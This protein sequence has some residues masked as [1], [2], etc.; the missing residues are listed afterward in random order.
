M[1][2]PIAAHVIGSCA[3]L[4]TPLH[5]DTLT[6][7]LQG[8]AT[9]AIVAEVTDQLELRLEDE[10]HIRIAGLEQLTR[11][12]PDGTLAARAELTALLKGRTIALRPLAPK[13]D[14]WGRSPAQVFGPVVP[15]VADGLPPV[16]LPYLNEALV[17]AG[18]FRVQPLS[19][20]NDCL[21]ILLRAEGEARE[22]GFGLWA[23]PAN[24]PI[25]AT[26]TDAL[27]ARNGQFTLVQGRVRR[28]GQ[29]RA[30]AYVDFGERRSDFS[31]VVAKRNMKRFVQAGKPLEGLTGQVLRVRGVIETRFGA[32]IEISGPEEMEIISGSGEEALTKAVDKGTGR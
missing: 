2:N 8:A 20:A 17:A 31:I 7:C 14:R 19:E 16:P 3:V 30:L 21:A 27:A 13:S 28:V 23:D 26:D 11:L 6:P 25:D 29:G 5:A 22:A 9:P 1:Q 32:Q 4:A 10:R 24:A 18:L 15:P 12:S